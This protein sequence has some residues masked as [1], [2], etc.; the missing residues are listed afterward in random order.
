MAKNVVIIGGGASGLMAAIW[1]SRLGAAV[2][3]LE[4]NDK[5]GRKLLA[6]GNGRCNFTNRYQDASCYR[7][8]NQ[9]RASRVLEQFTEQDT[10]Q[11]FEQLGIRIRSREGWLYPAS[12]QAQSVLDLL[13]LE[14]RFRK[15]KIK[16][17]ETAVAVE[18]AENGYLV[19]TEGWQYP[20]DS[21]SIICCGS[22]P[23][24]QIRT[25]IPTEI[26][27]DLHDLTSARF[28]SV[29]PALCPLRAAKETQ[30]FL[31]GRVCSGAREDYASGLVVARPGDSDRNQESS[32]LYRLRC[33]RHPGI[34]DF[35][36]R[37]ARLHAEKTR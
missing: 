18:K 19:R 13:V 23:L 15:V 27:C 26:R 35:P 10:E 36:V 14:A 2:T 28:D 3:V 7:T 25:K 29:F 30:F 34:P 21:V 12:E 8:G 17:R 24:P 22:W 16:T 5:P 20:A 4:K 37:C 32:Q 11:F 9:E 33:L 6:T 31:P 1:A